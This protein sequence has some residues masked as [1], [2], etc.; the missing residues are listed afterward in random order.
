MLVPGPQLDTDCTNYSVSIR[1]NL[2][3]TTQAIG[4]FN[5]T[6]V[7]NQ[8]DVSNLQV[9]LSLAVF[10]LLERQLVLEH[11]LVVLVPPGP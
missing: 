1:A 10:P 11:L 9:L 8:A 2:M 6:V 5:F 7:L 3:D 4:A